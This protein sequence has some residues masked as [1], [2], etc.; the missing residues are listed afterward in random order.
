M[1]LTLLDEFR[2]I[3]DA[4]RAG[5]VECA[6]VGALAVAVHGAPRATTDVDLLIRPEDLERGLSAV[7]PLGYDL[8]ALRM[9]FASGV[10]VQR[11]TKV[12]EGEALTLD[13]LLA[14][15]ALVEAWRSRI[16]VEALDRRFWVVSRD[17]LLRMKALSGRL[18][19][20]ADIRRLEG[21]ED[22]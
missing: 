11:V 18:Q 15:G 2:A 17:A 10:T 8:P 16:E 4:L 13:F 7:R 20:L 5:G 22:V 1:A 21:D 14:E 9:T 6:L 19:D 3:V 12:Q